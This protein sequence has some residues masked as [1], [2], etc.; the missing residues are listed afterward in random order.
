M[1]ALALAL[2]ASPALA[3]PV[4]HF[5]LAWNA[6]D[7][8]GELYFPPVVCVNHTYTLVSGGYKYVAR[9]PSL[10]A[11]VTPMATWAT[12]EHGH[13]YHVVGAETYADP[14]GRFVSKLRFINPGGGITDSVNIVIRFDPAPHQFYVDFG[15]CGF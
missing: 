7:S 1:S 14:G 2:S 3:A 8:T 15:T 4:G 10:A 13:P 6:K 12:D 5:Y 11:H 9:D